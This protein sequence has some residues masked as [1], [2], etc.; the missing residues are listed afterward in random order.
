VLFVFV[1]FAPVARFDSITA[2]FMTALAYTSVLAAPVAGLLGIVETPL[3][4][5]LP[6][7][8]S[9]VLLE[10]A[11][12]PVST[13]ELGYAVGYLALGTVLASEAARRSFECHVVADVGEPGSDRPPAGSGLDAPGGPV[14]SL[15]VADLKNWVRDPLLIYIGVSPLVLGVSARYLVPVARRGLAGT[16]DLGAQTP[17]IAA[18]LCLF[19]PSIIGFAVGF[20]VLEDREQ[21]TVTAL[22]VTPLGG[23]GYL[24]YRL[25]VTAVLSS[26]A[27]A[28][29]VLLSGLVTL[30]PP[31]LV[32]IA[33]VAG[34]Y[35][36]VTAL[37]LSGL[38]EN[39]IEGIAVSKFLGFLV[40]VPVGVIAVVGALAVGV[41]VQAVTL[42]ALARR[43]FR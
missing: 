32:G 26:A 12:G 23:R 28:A 15:A 20:L 16:H 1:G 24:T 18:A 29:V 30:T 38:A 4:Y 5:L 19:G 10:A 14:V 8:P 37:L 25:G 40:M 35:G 33:V 11:L 3:F 7:Q 9:L 6:A 2:Y 42:W 17:E 36:P 43:F 21:G 27:A 31:A 39:T 22:R 34:L 41:V 13:L